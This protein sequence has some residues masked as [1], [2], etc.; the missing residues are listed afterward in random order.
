MKKK[1]VMLVLVGVMMFGMCGCQNKETTAVADTEV[2]TEADTQ[3][4]TQESASTEAQSSL[5]DEPKVSEREDYVGVHE[6]NMDEYVVL[7][8]YK[9]MKITAHKPELTDESIESYI[10]ANLLVGNITDRAVKEGDI[11]DIDYVGKKDG[12]AFDGG[13]AQGY[14]LEIGSGT[15]IDGFEDGLVGVMPGETVDL[16]LTFPENYGSEELA[17]A[18]VVFTVTVNSILGSAEYATVTDEEMASLGIEA[19]KEELWE[20]AKAAVEEENEATF[21]AN[22]MN[23]ILSQIFEES[24]VSS[25]PQNLVD[26]EVQNY[27]VY[28]ESMAAMYGMDVETLVSSAQGVTLDEFKLQLEESSKETVEQYLIVEAILRAEGLE[29]TEEMVNEK[30]AEEATLYGYESAEKLVEE[31][32]YTSYR[33]YMV[34][35]LVCERLNEIITVEATSEVE[36]MTEATTEEVLTEE[37]ATEETATEETTAVVEAN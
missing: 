30:A 2:S 27:L 15:F 22:A 7:N 3:A 35:D 31:V 29:V 21:K 25:V 1:L 17:G 32:G 19:T 24:E 16:N 18:D 4:S 33:M 13:T 14:Q 11:A 23:A 36:T 6:L 9:N 37:A 10:N 26:E 28:L 12:V 34:R 20:K 5:A 8:D